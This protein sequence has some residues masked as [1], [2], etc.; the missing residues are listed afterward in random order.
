M[1]RSEFSLESTPLHTK[2]TTLVACQRQRLLLVGSTGC[3]QVVLYN[4]GVEA[5]SQRAAACEEGKGGEG[6]RCTFASSWCVVLGEQRIA[7]LVLVLLMFLTLLVQLLLQVSCCGRI[8][9]RTE[10]A[11]AGMR[12][13]PWCLGYLAS[14]PRRRICLVSCALWY[15]TAAWA[16]P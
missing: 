9:G 13:R 15:S 10:G 5:A 14:A 2:A 1:V 11:R 16:P 8:G 4:I 3:E 7:V 6:A 12:A